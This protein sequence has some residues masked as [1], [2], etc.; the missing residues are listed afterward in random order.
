MELVNWNFLFS[1]KNVY[2]QVVIFNQTLMNI[3]S[4]YMPK[5]L[6]TVDDKDPTWM[7][8]YMK[9]KIFDTKNCL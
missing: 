7:N 5:K 8:E 1:P 4:N 3:F 2:D 6:I 9:K